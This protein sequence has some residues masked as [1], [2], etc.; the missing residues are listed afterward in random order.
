MQNQATEFS[1]SRHMRHENKKH[2]NPKQQNRFC[3][4]TEQGDAQ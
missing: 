4:E 1:A 3:V 2:K